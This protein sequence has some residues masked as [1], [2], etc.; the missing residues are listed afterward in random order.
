MDP[1]RVPEPGDQDASPDTA[2]ELLARPRPRLEPQV[3]RA[4]RVER[5]REERM[6]GVAVPGAVRG[7][8]VVDDGT[9]DPVLDEGEPVARLALEVERTGEPLAVEGIVDQRHGAG[10]LLAEAAGDERAALLDGEP[11]ELLSEEAD[12]VPHRVGLEDDLVLARRKIAR[13]LRA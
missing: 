1:A 12:D 8:G 10:H 9:R 3:H 2:D 13:P 7:A 4:R 11:G 5:V 6:S